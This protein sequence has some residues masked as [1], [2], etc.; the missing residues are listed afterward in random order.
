MGK[1]IIKL[2]HSIVANW[3]VEGK[4]HDDIKE[5]LKLPE[6]YQIEDIAMDWEH[7]SGNYVNIT[8]SAP[9]IPDREGSELPLILSPIYRAIEGQVHRHKSYEL[10]EIKV[11]EDR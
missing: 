1:G 8:V 5:L 3:F 2:S 4:R 11:H 9:E 6:Q 10:Q 7:V